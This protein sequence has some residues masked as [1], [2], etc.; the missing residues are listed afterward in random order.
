MPYP[1]RVARRSKAKPPQARHG[2]EDDRSAHIDRREV[3]SSNHSVPILFTSS[4]HTSFSQTGLHRD[5]ENTGRQANGHTLNSINPSPTPPSLHYCP[6]TILATF[7]LGRRY[8]RAI[9]NH[10]TRGR[11]PSAPPCIHGSRCRRPAHSCPRQLATI[12]DAF[13]PFHCCNRPA[14]PPDHPITTLCPRLRNSAA[15]QY[16]FSLP[17]PPTVRHPLPRT[18]QS[19]SSS[20]SLL[21]ACLRG[22]PIRTSFH[23]G[24]SLRS[25]RDLCNSRRSLS[26]Q[27]RDD[28]RN[29]TNL[30]P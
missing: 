16:F 7:L 11:P 13:F 10:L 21:A 22:A 12:A 8:Q 29:G 4:T 17:A 26:T 18:R 23:L 5:I 1:A 24:H 27:A 28:L 25:S 2:V 9:F 14:G 30:R 15:C 3:V 19:P 20:S 6:T